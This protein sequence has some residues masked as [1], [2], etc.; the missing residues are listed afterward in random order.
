MK[1][2]GLMLNNTDIRRNYMRKCAE[3]LDV[4]NNSDSPKVCRIYGKILLSYAHNT[5]EKQRILE[6]MLEKTEHK[7]IDKKIERK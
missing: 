5:D 2:Q 4:Q 1:I 7:D 3:L 6:N